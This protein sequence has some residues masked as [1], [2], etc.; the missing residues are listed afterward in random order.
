MDA[1]LGPMG[2][3]TIWLTQKEQ[4]DWEDL[5]L[6]TKKQYKFEKNLPY[7]FGVTITAASEQEAKKILLDMYG[8]DTFRKM[9]LVSE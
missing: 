8:W 2:N 5:V 9:K 6:Y 4:H 1:T 3:P 7:Y